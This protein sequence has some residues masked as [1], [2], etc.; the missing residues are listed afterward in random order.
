[1]GE[2]QILQVAKQFLNTPQGKSLLDSP[3]NISDITNRIQ[4]LSSK[5]NISI[6]T[7]IKINPI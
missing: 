7:N 2:D 5:Y 1:M 4:E 6:D 3:L